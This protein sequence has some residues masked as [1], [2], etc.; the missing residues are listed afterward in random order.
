M[1]KAQLINKNELPQEP[2]YTAADEVVSPVNACPLNDDEKKEPKQEITGFYFTDINGNPLEK[3]AKEE[4]VMLVIESE[5]MSGEEVVIN[6]P[7]DN[8]GFKYKGEEVTEDKVLKLSIGSN[9]EKIK[10]ETIPRR[11]AA[12]ANNESENNSEEKA[13]D[14][15]TSGNVEKNDGKIEYTNPANNVL[16]W[17]EQTPK[18]IE[19]AIKSALQSKNPGKRVEG[20]VADYVAQ[21]GKE[22][23]A[24]G[25][26]VKNTTSNNIAGDIDVMTESEIIEV[27]KSVSSFKKGQVDKFTDTSLPNYL[28]PDN[29]KAILYIDEPMSEEEKTAIQS[30]IPEGTVLTNSLD[31]LGENLK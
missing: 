1:S 23:K 19:Q 3:I 29:K 27:K 12:N 25:Q 30:K 4:E 5:N 28:N 9:T 20:K 7:A 26:K 22:V 13:D 14:T 11:K 10:L 15:G 17:K 21:Q 24:F 31:E 6:L 16:T 2:S 18:S 8:V